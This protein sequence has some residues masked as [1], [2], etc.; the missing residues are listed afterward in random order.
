MQQLGVIIPY[1][2][3][4][5]H[6]LQIIPHLAKYFSRSSPDRTIP[7]RFLVVEQPPGEP[8]NRGLMCNVGFRLLHESVDYVC[9]HDVDYLPMWADY[10]YPEQPTMI[11]W[12]GFEARPIDP[13]RPL[14][15]IVHKLEASFSAVVLFRNEQFERVNGFPTVYWGW[16]YED[17][18]MQFRLAATGLKVERRKGTFTPLDHRNEGYAGHNAPTAANTRNLAVLNS[19]FSA[20]GQPRCAWQMD[21]L[22]ST[23]FTISSRRAMKLPSETRADLQ[24]EQVL[25]ELPP[26]S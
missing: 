26:K 18:E 12:Y 21:G 7:V 8:F 19:R 24:A 6:L 1:R 14:L 11:I 2:N 17:T 3:R 20:E 5:D 10:S 9:F 4:S 25:I 22:S 13:A 23:R 16:G 15:K